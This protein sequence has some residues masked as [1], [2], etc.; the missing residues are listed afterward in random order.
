MEIY[1]RYCDT[2]YGEYLRTFLST[3]CYSKTQMHH[4]KIF[5]IINQIHLFQIFT[6]FIL[7]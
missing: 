1:V 2:D 6:K 7:L 5:K 4:V 3:V